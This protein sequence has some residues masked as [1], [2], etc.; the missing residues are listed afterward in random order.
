MTHTMSK[1]LRV[2]AALSI[3]AAAGCTDLTVEPKSTI[4]DANIFSDPGSYRAFLARIYSGLAVSGQQGAAGQP[5]IRGIDEGFSQYLRLYWELENLP[6]DEA[7]IGWGDI[8]LPELNT[9]LWAVNNTF[10]AAMYYRVYFQVMMANEFLR[11]TT[12]AKLDER[13]VTGT[14]RTEIATYRAEARFLRAL[15]YWHGLD[16]FGNI[17]LVTETDALG[18]NPPAQSQRADVYA[19]VVSELTAILPDLPADGVANYGR[20]TVSAGNMLLAKLYL[21]AEV[22]TGTAAYAQALSAASAVIAGGYSLDNNYTDIFRADNNTSP[23]IIFPVVQ[24]GQRT[25]T[26]GGM[27]FLVHASCG[28]GMNAGSY[29][30]DGCWWGLRLRPEAYNRYAAGDGRAAYF[31]TSGQTGPNVASIGNWFDGFAAPKFQ[32]VTSTGAAGSNPTHVDTDFPMFRLADAYLIYAEAN[33][34]G[35]GGSAG[36][37]LGYVNALRQRAYGGTSGDITAGQ[38][39]LDFILDERSRELLWEGHRRNDLIR[40]GRFAGSAYNWSWKG[41]TLA[42][43][44]F[45]SHLN[46]YPI[47]ANE[48]VANPNLTQNTGYN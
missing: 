5:D 37:A 16:L 29:G 48:L 19:Y 11:Q 33:L 41:G 12:D 45:A 26:W 6:A 47:P 1:L 4:T 2:A 46:L 44:A 15:S 32:N 8:G 3:V 40:F 14:L 24:D 23:E 25:Q 22:Y 21:N 28:G 43:A 10:V 17:P 38:L 34:R 42:G 39:T 20:A 31:Y 18:S 9:G 27:T 30:I 36:T 13:G 35:G 7:V